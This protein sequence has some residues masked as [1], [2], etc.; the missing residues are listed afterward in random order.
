MER[1][2]TD[3]ELVL[4][5]LKAKIGLTTNVRDEYLKAIVKSVM[6][7]LENSYAIHV[8]LHWMEMK[9]LVVDF[10][11]YRYANKEDRG[12]PRDIVFRIH[13]MKMRDLT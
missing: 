9:M 4:E 8:D 3:E 12:V 7:E 5:I 11:Y 10:A 1:R 6:E 13:N 2:K